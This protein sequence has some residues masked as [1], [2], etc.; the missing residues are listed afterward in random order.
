MAEEERGYSAGSTLLAFFLGG[1]VGAGVALLLAPKSG[2]ETRQLIKEYAGDAREKAEGYLEKAK[3]SAS[4]V[5]DKVKES[6]AT[7]LEKG[8]E[9]VEEQKTI[10]TSAVEAGKEAYEKEKEKLAGE[11]KS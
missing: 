5:V 11:R 9:F 2:S 6:A 7:V 10:I 8:K 1:L 4:T 3:G